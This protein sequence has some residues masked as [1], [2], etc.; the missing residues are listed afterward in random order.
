VPVMEGLLN[1]RGRGKRR[2]DMKWV[3]G[4]LLDLLLLHNCLCF[5]T[6]LLLVSVSW[7]PFE[8]SRVLSSDVVLSVFRVPLCVLLGICVGGMIKNFVALIQCVYR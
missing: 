1:S 8:A 4:P 7:E 2:E 5:Y 3:H 6:S